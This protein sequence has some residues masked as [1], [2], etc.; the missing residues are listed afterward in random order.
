MR[1]KIQN[2]TF[3]RRNFQKVLK[4]SFI[5]NVLVFC[6]NF[7]NSF[8]WN[9][10]Y[11]SKKISYGVFIVKIVPIFYIFFKYSSITYLNNS[12][13]VELGEKIG[14]KVNYFC[15]CISSKIIINFNIPLVK[16]SISTSLRFVVS[17]NSTK[18]S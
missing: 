8:F 7:T 15:F 9:F 5:K 13:K 11:S 1:D 17:K 12:F 10:I 18:I 2:T 14:N 4:N 3:E 16:I 6:T